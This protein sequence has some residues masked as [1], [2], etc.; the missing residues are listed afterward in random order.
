M[1][2]FHLLNHYDEVHINNNNFINLYEITKTNKYLFNLF[3][4]KLKEDELLTTLSFPSNVFCH[5]NINDVIISLSKNKHF[6]ELKIS[7]NPGF[8][9]RYIKSLNN[10][11]NKTKNVY[12]IFYFLNKGVLTNQDLLIFLKTH[13]I[14][15]IYINYFMLPT[16]TNELIKN[17]NITNLYFFDE[18]FSIDYNLINSLSKNTSIKRLDFSLCR[19]SEIIGID[20][21]KEIIKNNNTINIL[22]LTGKHIDS[23]FIFD[24]MHDK[25]NITTLLLDNC[26]IIDVFPF[27][28]IIRDNEQLIK[29]SLVNNPIKDVEYLI[30]EV[31]NNVDR[32]FDLII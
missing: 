3:L 31:E 14:D 21:L 27:L 7:F 12:M 20:S 29:L 4:N 8:K 18:E 23:F 9:L 11:K 28:Q 15:E 17:N 13:L 10:L 32:K 30:D 22:D 5:K 16:L 19:N 24:I 25:N 6:K 26:K 1:D 2:F